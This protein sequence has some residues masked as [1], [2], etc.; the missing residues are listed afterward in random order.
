V[1]F[2]T[3]LPIATIALCLSTAV[4][5]VPIYTITDL[6]TLGGIFSYGYDI[7]N[8]GQVT[9]FADIVSN[10]H[11]AF[12]YSGGSMTDLGTL[13]GSTSYGYDINDAGQVTGDSDT[14]GN[15]AQHAFLYSGGSMVDINSLISPTSG[16]ELTAARGINDVG[17]ITGYGVI[18]GQ[19]HAFLLTAADPEP[20]A[21]ALLG[22]GFL[23]LC[24]TRY[25]LTA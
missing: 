25:K 19:Q 4:S 2:K 20:A 22:I 21:L 9:G 23:G 13:G 7:N 14:V 17:Q 6:G 24:A 8:A 16:W 1:L 3:A 11:H 5:A 18:N 10:A 15:A 12:L